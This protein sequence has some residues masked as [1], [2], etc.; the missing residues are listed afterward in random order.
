[1]SVQY[2]NWSVYCQFFF[3][4]KWFLQ[5]GL[6]IRVSFPR[7]RRHYSSPKVL[8]FYMHEPVQGSYPSLFPVLSTIACILLPLQRNTQL[9]GAHNWRLCYIQPILTLLTGRDK[10]YV[11]ETCCAS[12]KYAMDPNTFHLHISRNK[13]QQ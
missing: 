2:A 3:S 13:I 7:G 6:K 1:M 11:F 4:E 5:K 12:R 9:T 10:Q 8:P